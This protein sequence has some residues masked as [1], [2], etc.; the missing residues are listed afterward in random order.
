MKSFIDSII[1]DSR[2]LVNGYDGLAAVR[3]VV[4]ANL[5][6]VKGM[7]VELKS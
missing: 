4:A 2:P 7:P 5:S 1:N 3:A 6:L